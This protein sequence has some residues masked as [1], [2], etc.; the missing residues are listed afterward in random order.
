M[1]RE[2][3]LRL[4]A[5]APDD[6]PPRLSGLRVAIEAA[7]LIFGL[8]DPPPDRQPDPAATAN[9]DLGSG[10]ELLSPKQ[11]CW[12]RGLDW[13]DCWTLMSASE[14][15]DPDVSQLQQLGLISIRHTLNGKEWIILDAGRVSLTEESADD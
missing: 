9:P 3:A 6:P 2:D 14:I 5:V 12:L 1:T 13:N 8:G 7:L 11:K 4:I 10:Q 15:G